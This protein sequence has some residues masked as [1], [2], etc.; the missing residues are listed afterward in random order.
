MNAVV[1]QS[2]RKI[3]FANRRSGPIDDLGRQ[4]AVH[5]QFLTDSQQQHIGILDGEARHSAG[6]NRK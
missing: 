4:H 3:A 6:Q 5:A 1:R 2:P